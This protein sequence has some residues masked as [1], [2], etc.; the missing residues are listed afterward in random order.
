R[1][2]ASRPILHGLGAL[3]ILC[4]NI[5]ILLLGLATW[6]SSRWQAAVSTAIGLVGIVTLVL[7][8]A[9]P[10]LGVGMLERLADWPLPAWLAFLGAGALV[11]SVAGGRAAPAAG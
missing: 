3:G 8:V 1:P 5:G 9:T 11:P 6:R 2:R 7:L 4:G 10:Q